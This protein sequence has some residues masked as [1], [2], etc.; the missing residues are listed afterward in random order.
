[1]AAERRQE[2]KQSVLLC[3]QE[4]HRP[5]CNG[6]V[7]LGEPRERQETYKI[8]KNVFKAMKR[9]EKSAIF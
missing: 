2:S 8:R 3:L 6:I 9:P 4:K 1:M 5:E 7:S